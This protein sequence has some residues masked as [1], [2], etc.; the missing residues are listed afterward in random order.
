MNTAAEL[1]RV[2]KPMILDVQRESEYFSQP[3]IGAVNAPLD[4]WWEQLDKLDRERPQDVYCRSGNRSMFFVSIMKS[5][6]FGRV[7]QCRGGFEAIAES[8]QFSLTDSVYPCTLSSKGL[9]KRL[10]IP[11][12]HSRQLF[13]FESFNFVT[14]YH[15]EGCGFAVDGCGK[16]VVFP[17]GKQSKLLA[18]RFAFP[19]P[20][21]CD[22]RYSFRNNNEATS[23]V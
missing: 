22:R 17:P 19:I 2:E 3:M 4:Y 12:E 18:F 11:H 6:G 15:S 21:L 20:S 14:P 16:L 8:F 1:A 9:V 13:E 7:G 23:M 5:R 10:L